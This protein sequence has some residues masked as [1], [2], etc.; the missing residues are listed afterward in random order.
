MLRV[1][2]INVFYGDLQVLWDVTFEVKET[3]IL[4][5]VGANGAGKSTTLKTISSLLTPVSGTIEFNCGPEPVTIH[6]TSP[7]RV[8]AGTEFHLNGDLQVILDGGHTSRISVW[9]STS[10]SPK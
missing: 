2:G 4:V 1:N 10:G 7:L 5:L 8:L 9:R 3:E 6:L